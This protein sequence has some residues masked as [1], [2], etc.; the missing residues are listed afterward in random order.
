M[1]DDSNLRQ[2]LKRKYL[3]RKNVFIQAWYDPIEI[4]LLLRKNILLLSTLY[5]HSMSDSIYLY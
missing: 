2:P 1:Q 3:P 5:T 4:K